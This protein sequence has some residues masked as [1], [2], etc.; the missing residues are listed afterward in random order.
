MKLRTFVLSIFIL[1]ISLILAS[2]G[3][4]D[5]SDLG[6]HLRQEYRDEQGNFRSILRGLNTELSG[7]K[8]LGTSVV[9][10]HDDELE[11][12][13]HLSDAPVNVSLTQM[14]IYQNGDGLLD[15]EEGFQGMERVLLA[16]DADLTSHNDSSFSRSNGV[17]YYA[18]Q[19]HASFK[20]VLMSIKYESFQLDRS[21]L[22]I[23]AYREDQPHQLLPV[24]C[25]KFLKIVPE[26]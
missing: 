20:S 3:N 23:F 15:I 18:Y 1:G 11:V 16:L 14:L 26:N 6:N 9:R 8:P 13:V 19:N 2:C 4:R 7:R 21:V 10:I 22:A 12:K 5:G 25:G 24:A 17:G